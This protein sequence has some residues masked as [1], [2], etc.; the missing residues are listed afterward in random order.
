MSS[1]KDPDTWKI[2]VTGTRLEEKSSQTVVMEHVLEL[3]KD[4]K[5]PE[6]GG[7][8]VM[9]ITFDTDKTHLKVTNHVSIDEMAKIKAH[10][11]E[12]LPIVDDEKTDIILLLADW[13]KSNTQ[14]IYQFS[15]DREEP[16]RHETSDSEDEFL[17]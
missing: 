7:H 1:D 4:Y 11:K 12:H 10:S 3:M 14:R 9:H 8:T 2:S 17:I 5:A 15:I 16:P 13:T 6:R